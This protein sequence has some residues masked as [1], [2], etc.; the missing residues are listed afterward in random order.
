M[1]PGRGDEGVREHVEW[2]G[3]TRLVR[4]EGSEPSQSPPSGHPEESRLPSK[5]FK[6]IKLALFEFKLND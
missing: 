6:N 5:K 3:D 4:G 1:E 2:L